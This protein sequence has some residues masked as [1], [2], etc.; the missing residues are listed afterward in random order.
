MQKQ[1]EKQ[2]NTKSTEQ[3]LPT[4]EQDINEKT[5][6]TVPPEYNVIGGFIGLG[7]NIH[8]ETLKEM[9]DLHD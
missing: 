7:S 4:Q 5:E 9:D 6:T 8:L 2:K 3:S 1:T